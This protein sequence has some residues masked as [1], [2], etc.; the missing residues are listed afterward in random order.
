MDMFGSKTS[1][2]AE[3]SNDGFYSLESI[4]AE[5][6]GLTKKE[7]VNIHLFTLQIIDLANDFSEHNH[8]NQLPS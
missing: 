3:S 5:I 2:L 4:R 7:V 8:Y 1:V 6:D